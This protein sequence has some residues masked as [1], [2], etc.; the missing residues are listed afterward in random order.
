MKSIEIAIHCL[1]IL[2]IF[3]LSKG[4]NTSITWYLIYL[5]T[6]A[7]KFILNASNLSGNFD[8]PETQE[9]KK[10]SKKLNNVRVLRPKTLCIIFIEVSSSPETVLL[11]FPD[12]F[13]WSDY[14]VA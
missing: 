2:I 10:V 8:P 3:Y 9:S 6:N 4:F 1:I 11:I 13:T 7:H 5:Y 12:T 14:W